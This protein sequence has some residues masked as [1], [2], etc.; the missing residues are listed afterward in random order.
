MPLP[1]DNTK[2]PFEGWEDVFQKYSEYAAWYSGDTEC[3]KRYYSTSEGKDRFWANDRKD[4]VLL[5]IV[6]EI[7]RLSADLLFSEAPEINFQND[8]TKKRMDEILEQNFF[9]TKALEAAETQSPMGGIYLKI[10]YDAD[11]Y[12]FPLFS[13]AQPDN[14]I[15]EFRNGFLVA[16]DFFKDVTPAKQLE[17]A[18]RYWFVE[19]RERGKIFN[20]L[21]RGSTDKL[22][23]RINLETLNFTQDLEEEVNTGID[24]ILVRYVPNMLPNPL[25]RGSQIGQ[26]DIAQAITLIETLCETYSDWRRELELAKARI[27]VPEQWLERSDDGTFKFDKDQELFTTLQIDPLSTK[28]ASGYTIAQFQIR[29][30]QYQ[31]TAQNLIEQIIFAAGYSPQSFGLKGDGGSMT[32]T[33]IKS[34]QDRTYKTLS[35]KQQYWKVALEDIFH[36]MLEVDNKHLGNQTTVERP[37]V[38]MSD[39]LETDI[40]SLAETINLLNRADAITNEMKVKWLHSDLSEEEQQEEIER[41]NQAQGLNAPN[42]MQVGMS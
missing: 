38:V 34:R 2:L 12:D 20:G 6:N 28:G 9:Q 5:P 30:E 21:Y 13:I 3:L 11:N 32:A 16:A 42:P 33:E 23:K 19:R 35:K 26:S 27:V 36:L 41:L 8:E 7:A 22:G 40:K 14:V 39:S 24:D 31:E 10:N 29:S 17:S 4:K 18:T 1:A 37:K 15:P 25:W